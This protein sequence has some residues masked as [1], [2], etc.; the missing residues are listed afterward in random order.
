MGKEATAVLRGV[1][2]ADPQDQECTAQ[3]F[4]NPVNKAHKTRAGLKG[5]GPTD[6][7][8]GCTLRQPGGRSQREQGGT[9]RARRSWRTP[10]TGD[11]NSG[12]LNPFR[13]TCW[14]GLLFQVNS[15]DLNTA[16]GRK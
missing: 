8:G 2:E 14:V 5:T 6:R 9:T 1:E 3:Q 15:E 12:K 4:N 11:A 10:R 16:T 13:L 7:G